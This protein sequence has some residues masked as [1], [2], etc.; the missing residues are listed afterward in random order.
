MRKHR[1]RKKYRKQLI[2]G[3]LAGLVIVA[4]ATVLLLNA[5]GLF[6]EKKEQPAATIEQTEEE[7]EPEVKPP[8]KTT[9]T[10]TERQRRERCIFSNCMNERNETSWYCDQHDNGYRPKKRT[11]GSGGGR[12]S[13][14][15]DQDI[16]S[17]YEDYRDEFED[18]DD[19][20]D[21]LEDNEEEWDD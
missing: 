8:V 16:D 21:D 18:I 1:K 4:I 12:T 15:D 3:F 11:S 7:P 6:S 5:V 2:L 10:G 20:W 14:I 13:T 9:I 17:Y 19:A